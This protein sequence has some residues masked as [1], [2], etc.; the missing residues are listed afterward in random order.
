MPI[1]RIC[2]RPEATSMPLETHVIHV[3]TADNLKK[4]V[5]VYIGAFQIVEEGPGHVMMLARPSVD[6]CV[7]TR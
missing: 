6:S 3:N 2:W 1:G 5:S 4:M 7:P